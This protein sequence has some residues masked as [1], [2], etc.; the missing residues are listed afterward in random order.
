[1]EECLVWL[2]LLNLIVYKYIEASQVVDV[3]YSSKN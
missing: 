3:R 2:R 1:M